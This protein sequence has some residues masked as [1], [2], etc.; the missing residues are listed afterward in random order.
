MKRR[1]QGIGSLEP[2]A[3][4]RAVYAVSAAAQM[5]GMHPQTLRQ[6][7]RLGLVSPKRSRGRGRRY[8]YSDVEKLRYI[9]TLS[10][11]GINLEGIRRKSKTLPYRQKIAFCVGVL[12]QVRAFSR[13]VVMVKYKSLCNADPDETKVFELG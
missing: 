9:Q 13:R 1:G 4:H 11:A 6:Y 5:A 3:Y 8:S 7:D 10:Q 2:D 12:T